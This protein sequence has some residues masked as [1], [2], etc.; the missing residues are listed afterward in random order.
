MWNRVKVIN[1]PS[2]DVIA[3][4]DLKSR[5]RINLEY[6]DV[7]DDAV[8]SALL[9]AAVARVDGPSGLGYAMMSQTWRLTLDCFQ[10]VIIL[11]GSPIREVCSISYINTDG[12]EREVDEAVYKLNLDLDAVS[13]EPNFNMTWPSTRSQ[14]N[15]VKIDYKLGVTDRTKLAQDLVTAVAMLTGHWYENREA[16]IIGVSAKELPFGVS[17]IF[18]QYKRGGIAA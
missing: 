11:P 17:E 16:S 14:N 12:E 15:A 6:N 9:K 3:L 7:N 10:D 13:I 2:D 18:S 1:G 5:L 8:I 4:N